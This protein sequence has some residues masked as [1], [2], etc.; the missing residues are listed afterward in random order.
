MLK[1]IPLVPKIPGS[2]LNAII[3]GRLVLA[4]RPSVV[5]LS[6]PQPTQRCE[7]WPYM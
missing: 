1:H 2:P 3:I 4:Q 7:S 5:I 6:D